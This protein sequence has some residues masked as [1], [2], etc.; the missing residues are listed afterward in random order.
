MKFSNLKT[1][2]HLGIIGATVAVMTISGGVRPTLAKEMEATSPFEPSLVSVATRPA[3][4]GT[5]QTRLNED[6]ELAN[7]RRGPGLEFEILGAISSEETI[8]VVGR[9]KDSYWLQIEWQGQLGWLARDLIA[10]Q[11]LLAT[12]PTVNP[13]PV[14]PAVAA[15]QPANTV[16]V[17][18]G[19]GIEM[20]WLDD[21]SLQ[22]FAVMADYPANR[23]GLKP[24]DRGQYPV[25]L[26]PFLIYL[27]GLLG[28]I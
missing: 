4:A 15:P 26:F 24:G 17:Y 14:A 8:E 27:Y 16:G 10:D 6:T 9:A 3:Q 21:G 1:A 20:E 5:I 13:E 7:V 2:L 19:V 22:V 25:S 28:T 23:A 11:A 18:S 12:L